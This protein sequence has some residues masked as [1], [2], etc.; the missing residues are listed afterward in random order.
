M[1]RRNLSDSLI[2]N[3][4]QASCVVKLAFHTSRSTIVGWRVISTPQYL[5]ALAMTLNFFGRDLLTKGELARVLWYVYNKIS[6][7]FQPTKCYVGHA[8][9]VLHIVVLVVLPREKTLSDIKI[10][11]SI[12]LWIWRS[13]IRGLV[14]YWEKPWFLETHIEIDRLLSHQYINNIIIIQLQWSDMN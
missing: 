11:A 14:R 7:R 1:L 9:I 10:W 12:P 8:G 6:Q 3:I 13:S 4:N 2:L 5:S